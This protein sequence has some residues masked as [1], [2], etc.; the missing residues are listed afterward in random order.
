MWMKQKIVYG[1]SD[2]IEIAE[3]NFRM[4]VC[5]SKNWELRKS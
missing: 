5:V 4:E 2:G 1:E 3:L